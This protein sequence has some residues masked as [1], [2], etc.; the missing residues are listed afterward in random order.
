MNVCDV[1][2]Y[3]GLGLSPKTAYVYARQVQ[4][5]IPLLEARGVDLL[6]CGPADVAAVAQLWPDTHSSRGLL[7][8]SLA[9]A[10]LLLGRDVIPT[11]AV[12]VPPAPT[13]H[14]LAIGE[15]PAAALE[16]AAWDRGDLPGL[17]VLIGLYSALRRAEIAGLR[18]ASLETRDDGKWWRV[19]GKRGKVADV[20]VH[21][22]LDRALER[23]DRPDAWLFPG[24]F[25][26]P[27]D[28]STIWGWCRQV[29]RDAGLGEISTHRLRHTSLAEMNDRSGDLRAVQS[30]ARHSRPETTAGYTR[31]RS[32]R[33]RAVVAMV[34]YGRQ[35]PEDD[36]AVAS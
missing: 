30:I 23:F 36:E 18:W 32:A 6:S 12:R 3:M 21:P 8:A 24:R 9:A 17:A 29:A 27:V 28:P 25:G 33:M 20:P 34:D 31:T 10:W 11:R 22:Q 26:G 14:C 7:R 5:A 4:R 19:T 1:N 15:S 2:E 35:S 16:S 13:M